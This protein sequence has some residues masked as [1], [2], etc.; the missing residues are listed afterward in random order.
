MPLDSGLCLSGT[1]EMALAG[2]FENYMLEENELPLKVAA[3]SRCFRA[4]TSGLTE[5]K[6]IYRVHQFTKVEMFSICSATQSEHMIECFKNLQL[7]LFKKLGLKLRLLDMPPNE[8]GASA[9]QKY[10]IE[11][12][13][14]GRATW[15]EISSCSNCTDYQAKRLNIR[16]RTR[17]GDIKYTH[18]VNGTAAAIPRLL[19]GLLETHQVD[20]NIIQVP[21]VVAKYMETDIISKA[22]FIPEIK[23]IKHLK[24]DM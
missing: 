15:G 13:M 5:E 9:Y 10:D 4:E 14:P 12:W 1:S 19:I 16:Y 18:T 23:L 3:V 8:L 21:E 2:F 11:A 24:N 20:S 17:E 6:G 7:E 22:K